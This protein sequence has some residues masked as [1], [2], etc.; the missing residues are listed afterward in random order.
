M[1]ISERKNGDL[2]GQQIEKIREGDRNAFKDL[3]FT[4]FY[5]LCT[6]AFQMTKSEQKAK[7]IVQEVFYKLWERREKWTIHSSLK[8]YLYRSVRNEALNQIDRDQHR[9]NTR[10]ELSIYKEVGDRK[11]DQTRQLNK[12]DEKL[13]EEIWNIV[14][15][16]P[17]RRQSVFVLHRKHGLSYREIG[18]VLGISRKTVE[19]HM[20]LALNDIREQIERKKI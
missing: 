7:D 13:V 9:Q 18:Q 1:D 12:G 10:E 19:N 14:H 6:Y 11:A 2:E 16:L 15:D 8:A 5:D 4:Y 3:F 17:Q 20:G